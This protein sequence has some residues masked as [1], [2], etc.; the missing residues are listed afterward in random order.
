MVT[1][2]DVY[3][4]FIELK[5][6]DRRTSCAKVA[7]ELY[8][9]G[10][11]DH[12]LSRQRVRCILSA[13][14][15]GRALIQRTLPARAVIVEDRQGVIEWLKQHNLVDVP[16]ISPKVVGVADVMGAYVYG[17]N[18]LPVPLARTARSIWI[19]TT[20]EGRP[21][22]SDMPAVELDKAQAEL[23]ELKIKLVP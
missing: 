13:R 22:V 10:K 3:T 16:V 20:P 21:I 17:A 11:A 19:I 23:R 14:P 2:E 4:C 8:E 7:Q 5:R 1:Y 18:S 12:V 15:E 9:Q 6:K